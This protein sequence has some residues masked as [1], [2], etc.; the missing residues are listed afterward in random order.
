MI[1]Q[2]NILIQIV[3]SEKV[4][5]LLQ[6]R[7]HEFYAESFIHMD[8]PN[9]LD[10]CGVVVWV[11]RTGKWAGEARNDP[12]TRGAPSW[13]NRKKDVRTCPCGVTGVIPAMTSPCPG[14]CSSRLDRSL[15]GGHAQ[16]CL[17]RSPRRENPFKSNSGESKS[18]SGWESP[19]FPTP[20]TVW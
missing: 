8:L 17:D 15:L 14:A 7:N 6:T 20:P 11:P 19:D 5:F 16:G 3:F 12:S 9:T 18:V 1:S 10:I 4:V 2:T 13:N